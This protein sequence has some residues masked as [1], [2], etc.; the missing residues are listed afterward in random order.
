[1]KNVKYLP[2]ALALLFSGVASASDIPYCPGTTVT[3]ER[4]TVLQSYVKYYGYAIGKNV[5][6]NC[7]SSF[8]VVDGDHGYTKYTI[9][10]DDGF[11]NTFIC[12]NDINTCTV[13]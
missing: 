10:W 7:L 9:K 6:D 13:Y 3:P 2:V 12:Y 4:N 8:E 1:M 5:G 11:G